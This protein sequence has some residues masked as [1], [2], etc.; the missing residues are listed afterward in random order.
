MGWVQV[1]CNFCQCYTTKTTFF[2]VFF[3][4]PTVG[5]HCLLV[6]VHSMITKY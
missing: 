4:K 6:F 2:N 5:S 1:V 3:D